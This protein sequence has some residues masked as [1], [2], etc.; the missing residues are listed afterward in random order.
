MS[1]VQQKKLRK[2]L[3]EVVAEKRG[4]KEDSAKMHIR[5]ALRRG[6]TLKDIAKASIDSQEGEGP[7]EGDISTAE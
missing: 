3:K 5:R 2:V 7:E 1:R 6:K 4:I